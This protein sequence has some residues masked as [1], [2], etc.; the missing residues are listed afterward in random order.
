MGLY[1]NAGNRGSAVHSGTAA[2]AGATGPATDVGGFTEGIAYLSVTAASG[3][4]PS[5]AVSIQDS[6]DGNTWYPVASFTA[7]TAVTSQRLDLGRIGPFVRA[8]SAITGTT[9]SFTFTVAVVGCN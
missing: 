8:V 6:P 5:L 7:A 4:T 1:R 3:T 9:P 2:T